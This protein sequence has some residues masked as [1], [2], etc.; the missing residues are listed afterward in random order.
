MGIPRGMRLETLGK[1]AQLQRR[2]LHDTL[3]AWERVGFAPEPD[4]TVSTYP[5]VIHA[6]SQAYEYRIMRQNSMGQTGP[7]ASNRV[8]LDFDVSAAR[9]NPLPN[10]PLHVTSRAIAG[11]KFQ[12]QWVYD[13]VGQGVF[14]T[15]FEVYAGST[16]A[17]I[18]FA[19]PLTDSITA[20]AYTLA[21][22]GKRRYSFTTA[23]FATGTAK[24]FAVRA[25]NS[26]GTAEKNIRGTVV[27]YAD[28]TAQTGGG[29]ITIGR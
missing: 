27:K 12:V 23:A 7:Y 9:E 15:K 20:L 28:A 6:A 2:A 18:N 17:G 4:R 10:R 19:A 21:R 14:P 29:G 8:R 1:G 5:E 3:A 24:A 13:D 22:Y 11:G 16:V 25:L 26:A